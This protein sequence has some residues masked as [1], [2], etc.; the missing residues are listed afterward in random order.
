[1]TGEMHHSEVTADAYPAHFAIAKAFGG[2]VKPFD[3]YQGPYVLIG[4]ARLW[5]CPEEDS[6]FG[7][8]YNQDNEKKSAP[9]WLHWKNTDAFATTAIDAAR[10]VLA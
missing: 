10:E 2:T 7:Y 8:I 3:Q 5:L 1:M 9:F 4:A 6:G